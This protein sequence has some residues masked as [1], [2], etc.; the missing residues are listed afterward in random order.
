M[1]PVTG[2][3]F[4]AV[5]AAIEEADGSLCVINV[6]LMTS[7]GPLHASRS[8]ARD[9]SHYMMGFS[10]SPLTGFYPEFRDFDRLRVFAIDPALKEAFPLRRKEG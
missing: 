10:L 5:V 2:L 6:A 8:D 7:S 3:P 4:A 1:H 9:Q